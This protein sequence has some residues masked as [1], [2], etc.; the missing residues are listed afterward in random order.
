M[1]CAKSQVWQVCHGL[2]RRR[3]PIFFLS[4]KAPSAVLRDLFSL[5]IRNNVKSFSLHFLATWSHSFP[6]PTPRH[7]FLASPFCQ[8]SCLS[9]PRQQLACFTAFPR[10]RLRSKCGRG[11]EYHCSRITTAGS[12]LFLRNVETYVIAPALLNVGGVSLLF[13][14]RTNKPT[15]QL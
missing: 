15:N 13:G 8:A 14:R 4:R 2:H 1:F 3:A 12:S 9:S 7:S 6:S 11:S 10:S 5:K